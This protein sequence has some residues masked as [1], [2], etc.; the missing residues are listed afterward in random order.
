MACKIIWS[1]GARDD[2][3]NI[4]L[5]I[6]ADSPERAERLGYRL[7][8]QTDKLQEFPEIGRQ[9]P[10][11]RNPNIREIIIAPYRVIYR[12]QQKEQVVEIARIWH[13]ARGEPDLH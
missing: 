5:T 1:P 13:G 7:M 9:V 8:Q 12:L 2:L 3:C 10:E 6:A 4:V 11:Q